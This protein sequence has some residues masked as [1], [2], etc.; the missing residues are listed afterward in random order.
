MQAADFSDWLLFCNQNMDDELA[1]HTIAAIHE[2]ARDIE[3]LF[4]APFASLTDRVELSTLARNP[5][6]PLH[7]GA[8]RYYREQGAV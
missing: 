4:P 2:Q 3:K 6:V 5:P 8:E 7:P 1:Y